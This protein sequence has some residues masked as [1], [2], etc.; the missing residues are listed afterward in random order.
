MII[1]GPIYIE[2]PSRTDTARL[3]GIGDIHLGNRHACLE[4]LRNDVA[5]IA[6]DPSSYWIGLGDY[7]DF[8]GYQDRRYD[9]EAISPDITVAD[10]GKLGSKLMEKVRDELAPIKA[11]CIGLIEGNHEVQYQVRMNQQGL[12]AWLC[13]E[14]GARNLGYSAIFEIIWVRKAKT[15]RPWRIQFETPISL[16]GRSFWQVR[17]FAHHGTGF[18]ATTGGKLNKLIRFMNMWPDCDL[19]MMGHIHE[20]LSHPKSR[21]CLNRDGTQLIDRTQYGISCGGY[22]KTYGEGRASYGEQ[23]GYE[24]TTLSAA[25]VEFRPDKRWLRAVPQ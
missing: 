12:H 21:P 11:K 24:P 16:G 25:I 20:A 19:V 23:R 2:Y 9:P 7:A 18:A 1:P 5:E 14:L 13:V 22:L 15:K 17:V 6:V 8:I 10:M 4:R 3:W